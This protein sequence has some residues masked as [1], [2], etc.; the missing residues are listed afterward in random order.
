MIVQEFMPQIRAG[1]FA[2][3]FFGDRFSH[4][5]HRT[6]AVGDFRV[7]S[8]YSGSMALASAV[9]PGAI[10]LGSHV[11]S[12][13]GEPPTYARIDVVGSGD[14]VTLMEVEVNEPALGLDL[15]PGSA[16]RFADAVLA[17]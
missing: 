3:V 14:D 7:N 9:D 8:Q 6:A 12:L 17:E 10:R 13:L 4:A 1:E 5:L 15:A 11:L 2:L 16:A